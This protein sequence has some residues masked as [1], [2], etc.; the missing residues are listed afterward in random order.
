LLLKRFGRI[1]EAVSRPVSVKEPAEPS[2]VTR[3]A[4]KQPLIL[5]FRETRNDFAVSETDV[6]C[7]TN[8]PF[9]PY[10]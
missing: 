1:N 8:P 3:L 10:P 7:E 9:F 6:I 2:R 5:K 4:T